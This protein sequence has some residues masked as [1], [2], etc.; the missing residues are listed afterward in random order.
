MSTDELEDDRRRRGL[1]LLLL[2]G[3]VL[4]LLMGLLG[5]YV[6]FGRG[7]A[8]GAGQV[9]S[10]GVNGPSLVRPSGDAATRTSG[11]PVVV[12]EGGGQAVA[13]ATAE[14]G[15]GTAGSGRGSPLATSSRVVGAV[16]PGVPAKLLL[17][18]TNPGATPVVIVSVTARV[19]SVESRAE[20]G[21]SCSVDW[22]RV[23]SFRGARAVPAGGI[24]TIELPVQF[25]DVPD[26]N[27]DNCKGA[28]YAYA[29]R[30]IAEPA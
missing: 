26:I 25:V 30:V 18:L 12:V 27:Q 15:S 7:S 22:Y 8:S 21:P 6:L 2:L 1:F 11:Q 19:T 13:Q 14:S 10:P 3:A 5:G 23:E 9:V 28:T 24:M 16:A 20:T 17:T 29:Y 4:L